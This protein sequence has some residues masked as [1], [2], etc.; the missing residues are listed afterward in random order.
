MNDYVSITSYSHKPY[1]SQYAVEVQDNWRNPLS[2]NLPMEDM[3]RVIEN[4]VMNGYT[5]AWG[6]DVSEPGF[7]R[8]GLAYFVDTKKAESRQSAQA[9]STLSDARFLS[10]FLLLSS[11]SSA[12]TTGSL[13]TTTAC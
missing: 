9:S 8:N 1:Y 10:S 13:L 6:G 4:A 2:W 5:V 11:A 12:S 3:A 7:T